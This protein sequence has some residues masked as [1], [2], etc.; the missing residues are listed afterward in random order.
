MIQAPA[1]IAFTTAGAYS[2]VRYIIGSLVKDLIRS[3]CL[4]YGHIQ[5]YGRNERPGQDIDEMGWA[6]DTH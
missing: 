5:E 4:R 3:S 1:A 6:L 2:L